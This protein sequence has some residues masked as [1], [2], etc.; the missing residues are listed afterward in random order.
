MV[1]KFVDS[2]VLVRASKSEAIKKLFALPHL[3]LND[4]WK[5]PPAANLALDF[6]YGMQTSDMRNTVK[7]LHFHRAL[8]S[9]DFVRRDL[10][11]KTRERMHLG[12]ADEEETKESGR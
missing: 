6:I 8:I 12:L 3:D 7:Y 11:S 1:D 4:D 2:A 5:K 9:E 10:S